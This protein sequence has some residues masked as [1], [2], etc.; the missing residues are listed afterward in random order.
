MK[1]K[2]KVESWWLIR[3]RLIGRIQQLFSLEVGHHFLSRNILSLEICGFSF[4][5][6]FRQAKGDNKHIACFQFYHLK[7]RPTSAA[8]GSRI[9]A[10]TAHWRYPSQSG[11]LVNVNQ[12]LY[13]CI[14]PQCFCLVRQQNRRKSQMVVDASVRKVYM[15]ML[16]NF[17]KPSTICNF[18]SNTCL[19]SVASNFILFSFY[20]FLSPSSCF[21]S[22]FLPLLRQLYLPIKF[23]AFSW[24]STLYHINPTY[25][26]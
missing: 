9:V 15:L 8:R 21:S 7:D 26:T 19:T 10:T 1:K 22:F 11:E 13:S 4:N 17:E 6:P 3:K 14:Q 24:D 25:I 23:N 16:S 18:R 20:L 12:A 5:R 2:Q